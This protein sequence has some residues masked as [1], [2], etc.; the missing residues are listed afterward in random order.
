MRDVEKLANSRNLGVLEK[1][2]KRRNEGCGEID[3]EEE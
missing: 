2:T 3:K 1:A